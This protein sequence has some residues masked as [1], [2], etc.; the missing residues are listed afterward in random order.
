MHSW[1]F[2]A[3][4]WI[5]LRSFWSAARCSAATP[6]RYSS[7]VVGF[8]AMLLSRGCPLESGDV[9]LHHLQ[10]GVHHAL[11]L[12]GVFVLEQTEQGSGDDLPRHAELVCQPAALHFYPTG[13][14]LLP[15]LVD[16]RLRLAVHDERD[17]RIDLVRRP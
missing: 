4:A 1:A 16:F 7:I 11:R 12:R 14:E 17:R 3:A 6:A 2:G 15:I 5:I 13:R 8:A 10:Q 9:D